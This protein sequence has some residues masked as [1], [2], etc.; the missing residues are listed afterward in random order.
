[1]YHI[2]FIHSSGKGHLVVYSFWLLGTKAAMN[3][4]YLW[5]GRASFG[6]MTR[7]G[8]AGYSGR[9]IP[10]SLKNK[11]KQKIPPD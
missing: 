5:D 7:S 11:T 3:I 2:F 6:Y 1:M 9:T 4:V 8:I 10:S